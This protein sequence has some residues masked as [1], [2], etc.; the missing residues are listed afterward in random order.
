M[1]AGMDFRGPDRVDAQ[2]FNA[3]LQY[4]MTGRSTGGS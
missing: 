1:T 4:G 2:A 3:I